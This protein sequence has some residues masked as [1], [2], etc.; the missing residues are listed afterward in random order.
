LYKQLAALFA[1][2]ATAHL[3]AQGKPHA[4]Y[5][6][7][8]QIIGAIDVVTVADGHIRLAGWSCATEVVLHMNGI[9]ASA[10][11][12]LLRDDVAKAYKLDAHLGFDFSVPLGPLGL[13]EI[14]RF[15]I[16]LHGADPAQPTISRPLPLNHIRWIQLRVLFSFI[17][18]M[19]G[20]LP[21]AIGWLATRDPKYRA[22]IKQGLHL[23]TLPTSLKLDPALFREDD[24]PPPFKPDDSITIIMPVFNAFD[25]LQ[26]A[27]A[28][29]KD[30]TDLPWRLILVEDASTDSRVLPF[31]R[32][33]KAA[34]TDQVILLEN[35]ENLG[36]IRSVNRAFEQA[37]LW[38][39]PVILLNSD[40]LVPAGWAS[41]LIA[42]F[43]LRKNVAT[44]TPMSNNAEVFSIPLIC[45]PQELIS[46][47][48]DIIDRTAASL[49][50]AAGLIEAPTGVGFCMAINFTYLAKNP[51]FDTAYG[52]GYGEEVDWC[53]RVKAMSGQHLSAGNLF[54]EHRG[55]ESFGSKEKQ[56]LIAENNMKVR[57]RFPH[58]DNDVQRFVQS[59]PLR[60][61]RLALGLAWLGAQDAYPVSIYLA[62]SMGGGADAYL[63]NRITSKH[64]ALGRSAVILRVGGKQRWQIE[65]VTPHGTI[66][67]HT[68]CLDY[69]LQMLAPISC[70]RIVYSC[71]VGDHDPASL[72]D[73]LFKLS[74]NGRHTIEILLHDYFVISPSYTLLDDAGIY[75]GVPTVQHT[76]DP[77]VPS[78]DP[79]L[80]LQDWQTAW[81]TPLDHAKDVIVFSS[82]S[83]EILKTAYPAI[84]D[85]I[86][87]NP[88][89]LLQHVPVI[90]PRPAGG[91]RVIGVLGD[92][93]LQKGAGLIHDLAVIL[94]QNDI[95]LAIIGNFD[96]TYP[97]QSSIPIHGGYR[98]ENL[99]HICDRYGITDW[100]IPSIWPETFS[101]T[102]HEALA[103][104]LPVHAF[105]L[106]AQGKAVSDANN[107]CPIPFTKGE[108]QIANLR[109]HFNKT[110]YSIESAA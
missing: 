16:E 53:Q 24:S 45:Q 78:N 5:A 89:Q 101:F 14:A 23:T 74:N 15:G 49:N 104:G 68:N 96:T 11:P 63:S 59:D 84:S 29:V 21:S 87:I 46:G 36:F 43:K 109:D 94:G 91:R 92:I 106:G 54:V 56:K 73:A 83:A 10:W 67:G 77:L 105:N 93:G 51:N 26:D 65:L 100:L 17:L 12:D 85:K 30:H 108:C 76:P 19:L 90:Q 86:S 103:T 40:A 72:P 37:L 58:F 7:D 2:Y 48:G 82:S 47:Q 41:R 99:Q 110:P 61:T 98:I 31:L 1:R 60:S 81:A 13:A 33:W 71:G 75:H 34:N 50:Q 28:R 3:K 25:L 20:Q 57:Q 107:G 32:Q 44:V 35:K 18:A 42:P 8:G 6:A 64:H 62:H 70:R 9:T 66:A 52:R 27:L 80:S 22:R 88:H 97:I 55:G 38:S 39:D 95:G 102:T 4:F 69:V 79:K